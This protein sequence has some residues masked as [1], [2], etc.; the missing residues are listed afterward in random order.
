MIIKILYSLNLLMFMAGAAI[1][2]PKYR[3][4][5]YPF[6]LRMALSGKFR[7][8]FR[9]MLLAVLMVQHF[10]YLSIFHC[11]YDVMISTAMCFILISEKMSERIFHFLQDRLNF[12]IVS[13]VVCGIIAAPHCFM[14]GTVL[15]VLMLGAMFYPSATILD[16][17][18]NRH[19]R[20]NLIEDMAS[21]FIEYHRIRY[22]PGHVSD[23]PGKTSEEQVGN[24]QK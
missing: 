8:C 5:M 19:T 24:Q 22:M 9:L 11:H 3:I 20:H 16:A 13:L 17:W 14:I 7:K 4:S 10:Y 23:L 18:T 15:A 1:Y 12:F 6:Y 21:F 2:S